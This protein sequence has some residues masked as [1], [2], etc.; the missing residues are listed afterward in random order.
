MIAARRRMPAEVLVPVCD[1][2]VEEGCLSRTG[3]CS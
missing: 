3:S 2:M 1:R